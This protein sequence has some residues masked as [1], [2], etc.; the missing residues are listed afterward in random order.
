VRRCVVVSGRALKLKLPR[1]HQLRV[2]LFGVRGSGFGVEGLEF[3]VWGF[4]C[5]VE[6][7]G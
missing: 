3:G 1:I 5:G 7:G 2:R 6:F 4:E